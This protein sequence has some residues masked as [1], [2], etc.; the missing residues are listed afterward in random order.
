MKNDTHPQYFDDATV[1]CSCGTKFTLGSTVQKMETELCSACHP[2]YTGKRKLVDTEGRVDKFNAK[3]KL[4]EN[5]QSTHQ[6]TKGKK[7]KSK[8]TE[9]ITLEQQVN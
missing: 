3:R 7:D 9:S 5:F 4:A 6:N 1:T 8:K 2:F